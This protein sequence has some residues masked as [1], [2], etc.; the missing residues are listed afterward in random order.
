MGVA[1]HS[2]GLLVN[3]LAP[4]G[5]AYHSGFRVGDIIEGVNGKPLAGVTHWQ[6]PYILTFECARPTVLTIRRGH[7]KT[8]I[9]LDDT[10]ESTHQNT[11]I[12]DV[13]SVGVESQMPRK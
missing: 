12:T 8:A 2:D 5:I 9:F 11:A 1:N 7:S 6:F 4:T 10:L 13:I 3:S